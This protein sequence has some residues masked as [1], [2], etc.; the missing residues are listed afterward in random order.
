MARRPRAFVPD[1]P[2]HLIQR[3][4]NR[5]VCFFQNCDYLI[6]LAKLAEYA[7]R[8]GVAVHNYVLMT[9][10]VH[11]LV[12][13]LGQQS[14]SQMMHSL[15]AYYVRYVNARYKRTGT[16]WEGRYKGSMIDSERYLLTVSKYIELNPVRA[17]MCQNPAEYPWS[18]F[19]HLATG[20][21]NRIITPHPLYLALGADDSERQFCYRQLFKEQIPEL[22]LQEIREAC[23]KAWTLGDNQFK[24]EIEAQL[25]YTLP[26]FLRGR[27]RKRDDAPL[28]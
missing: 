3:G 9:N 17:R 5:C 2:V 14:V 26:P 19:R 13:P 16:L 18:S 20:H 24:R 27:P 15:G 1:V 11:L 25:G 10:H 22:S 28:S 21:P 12:T 23:S 8:F 6:Y 7:S 4:N